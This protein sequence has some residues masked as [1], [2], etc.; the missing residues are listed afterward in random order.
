MLNILTNLFPLWVLAGALLALWH[1]TLFTWFSGAL[2]PTGL[3]VIML[4]MGL[5]LTVGDFQRILKMPGRIFTGALLQYTVMP[6]LGWSMAALFQLPPSLAAGLILVACCPGG[7]AS[8]VVTYL[9]KADVP[10]SVTM[11]TLTTL[12]AVVMTPALTTWLVGSRVEVSFWGL[13][14]DTIQ[15]V[16]FP[17]VLG[18]S[19][20]R[21]CPK[22]TQRILPL[23]PLMA[24]IFITLIVSSI[25]GMGREL[26]LES[27]FA[28]IGAVAGLHA[29]GF[30]LGYFSALIVTRDVIAARTISIEV[31]MQNSG[32]GVVLA[33]SN[34]SSPL[35]AIPCAIS[36]VFHSLIGSLLAALW[37]RQPRC[38]SQQ[39]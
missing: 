34:F 36:S 25:V 16:V 5:T 33:R 4:G 18:V 17:V 19:L 8:N 14:R 30:F 2:I 15:V 9:A 7:T 29:G 10:L 6:F 11:T 12:M 24:V 20:N 32:L 28:L 1:P 22:I 23:A 13:L 39:D 38:S 35:V 37:R 31:G 21:F 27:G 26:I 3:G